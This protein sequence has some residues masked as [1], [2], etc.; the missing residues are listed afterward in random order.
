MH[1]KL[2]LA[3]LLLF[4]QLQID[5]SPTTP[6]YSHDCQELHDILPLSRARLI[7]VLR[8]ALDIATNAPRGSRRD[9]REHFEN[10]ARRLLYFLTR[11]PS[12][13]GSAS[14]GSS[15]EQPTETPDIDYCLPG[16]SF[17][18]GRRTSLETMRR[19]VQM[20]DENKTVKTI[21]AK[22]RWYRT[23]MLGDF[24][25]CIAEGGSHSMKREAIDRYARERVNEILSR[26][27]PLKPYMIRA[28]GR[29]GARINGAPWF[30]A[31]RHWANNFRKQNRLSSRKVTKRIS[32]PRVQN[33]EAIE[34]SILNFLNDFT[35]LS[36][37]FYNRTIWNIDQTGIEYEQ[38]N[39]RTIARTGS[40]DVF[41]RVDNLGK[42][43][44][45]YTAQP[46]LSRDG[47]LLGRLGICMQEPGGQFGPMVNRSVQQME[48]SFKNVKIYASSSGKMTSQLMSEWMRDV[49]GPTIA[50]QR[51]ADD[52]EQAEVF[53]PE[54]DD[55][56]CI[57]PMRQL[58]QSSCGTNDWIQQ[59][60]SGIDCNEDAD[61]AAHYFCRR[62][63]VMLLT[64]AW[65]GQTNTRIGLETRIHGARPLRIPPHTT[66]I[67]QPLDVGFFRQLKIFLRRI[68][69]EALVQDRVNEIS[70]R[71]GAINLLSI[72][73]NQFQSPAYNDLWR[74]AWRHTDPHFSTD[75]LSA[76]PPANVNSIQF[77]FDPNHECHVENCTEE[78]VVRSSYDGAPFCLTHFLQR[79]SVVDTI[80]DDMDVHF[81]QGVDEDDEDE[82]DMDIIPLSAIIRET[83]TTS[84]TPNP[85]LESILS[86][87]GCVS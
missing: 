11:D 54:S 50:E 22:Y 60:V 4:I 87:C 71:E 29:R 16:T 41:L 30:V 52:G 20:A 8:R 1:F 24:R 46:I 61:L 19:I 64:D 38:S 68:T 18:R 35:R 65:S 75:E 55:E 53:Q 62:P 83:P 82:E 59:A 51:F 57:G 3:F 45:S 66:D 79:H 17:G 48:R 58:Y 43:T 6:S 40:R 86:E 21:Q 80:N 70:S 72:I 74:Y 5:G 47:R 23:S 69:E 77:G 7:G 9:H 10:D 37:F 63:R 42:T 25:R 28:F 36:R 34:E 85:I 15:Q 76:N 2:L 39:E 56:N 13:D 78:V 33:Q 26:N 81:E 73:Y 14:S 31:S 67:L 27:L 49:L 84:T 12:Y 44:H 32:R